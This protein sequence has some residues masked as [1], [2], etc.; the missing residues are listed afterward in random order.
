MCRCHPVAS[1][2]LKSTWITI[3]C[4]CLLFC[5]LPL[6]F[7]HS[8]WHMANLTHPV[9]LWTCAVLHPLLRQPTVSVTLQQ[10][11]TSPCLTSSASSFTFPGITT[12]THPPL[13][14]VP[15]IYYVRAAPE[16]HTETWC[17]RTC[18]CMWAS[19]HV[20]AC[21]HGHVWLWWQGKV[22]QETVS[23]QV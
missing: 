3:S 5:S 14:L 20:Q 9:T 11:W 16:F 21:M 18:G 13:L 17:E 19:I 1:H 23:S 10:W 4:V 12:L 8:F 2:M 15:L 7:T 6:T 22:Q